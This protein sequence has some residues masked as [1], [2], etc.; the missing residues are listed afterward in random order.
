MSFCMWLDS[1]FFVLWDKFIYCQCT[2]VIHFAPVLEFFRDS[3]CFHCWKINVWSVIFTN[4]WRPIFAVPSGTGWGG[5][6]TGWLVTW[7]CPLRIDSAS[8]I[9]FCN[10]WILPVS[11]RIVSRS[12]IN[13]PEIVSNVLPWIA[14]ILSSHWNFSRE[15]HE[16]PSFASIIVHDEVDD[17]V[18]VVRLLEHNEVLFSATRSFH[19]TFE[20]LF[21]HNRPG[22]RVFESPLDSQRGFALFVAPGESWFYS[23]C[24]LWRGIS[25]TLG[26]CQT[27]P[28]RCAPLCYRQTTTDW[29]TKFRHGSDKLVFGPLVLLVPG[30]TV[31]KRALC[32]VTDLR[33]MQVRGLCVAGW[34]LEEHVSGLW[35]VVVVESV[36]L[37]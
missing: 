29:T 21:C 5:K 25:L 15:L 28:Q 16:D 26:M 31:V 20:H 14:S 13:S 8:L 27:V 35:D 32:V 10:S 6:N 23:F 1:L 34:L 11:A 2:K 36:G 17:L 18:V 30:W 7:E 3:Q 22:V 4:T 33:V 12:S 9:S 24:V 19:S 37:S